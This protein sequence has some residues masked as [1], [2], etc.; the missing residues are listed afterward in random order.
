MHSKVYNTLC[1]SDNSNPVYLTLHLHSMHL[2]PRS[3]RRHAHLI[4]YFHRFIFCFFTNP[5]FFFLLFIDYVNYIT[6]SI[7]NCFEMV[8]DC[9]IMDRYLYFIMNRMRIRNYGCYPDFDLHIL[10]VINLIYY[11]QTLFNIF[12]KFNYYNII[13]PLW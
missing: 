2:P 10:L 3:L 13:N 1:K 12:Q 9:C 5:Y 11:C 6:Y 4:L 7:L 8:V